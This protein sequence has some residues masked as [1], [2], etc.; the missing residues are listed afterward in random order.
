MSPDDEE[1][2]L[3]NVALQN[4]Q[5]ILVARKRAE[6]DL[7]RAKNALEQMA[8]ELAH[9][10]GLMRATLE[11][12]TD[13]ILVTDADGRVTDLNERFVSMWGLPADPLASGE[14]VEVHEFAR[15]HLEHP[16]PFLIRMEEI[17]GSSPPE[18]YDLVELGAA[19]CSSVSRDR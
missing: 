6:E 19:G 5:S 4:A 7:M 13:G 9:S 18:S 1:D 11:A 14:P 10:L 16:E 17:V 8:G 15:R 3:R 12:T 2:E